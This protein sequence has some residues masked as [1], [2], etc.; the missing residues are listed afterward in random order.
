MKEANIVPQSLWNKRREIFLKL[1]NCSAVLA[2]FLEAKTWPVRITEVLND[3]LLVYCTRKAENRRRFFQRVLRKLNVFFPFDL[4]NS[5]IQ[6][7]L[8]YLNPSLQ[9]LYFVH[10]CRYQWAEISWRMYSLENSSQKLPIK[11]Q[12]LMFIRLNLAWRT[13]VM[14][15]VCCVNFI[16]IWRVGT[17]FYLI[18]TKHQITNYG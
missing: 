7:C 10:F 17:M 14:K 2:I 3:L 11:D 6:F 18:R 15:S 9:L 16:A 4:D 8:D 5:F 12:G 13:A 1:R